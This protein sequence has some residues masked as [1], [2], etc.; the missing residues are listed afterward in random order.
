MNQETYIKKLFA[1]NR[2][3]ERAASRRPYDPD[4]YNNIVDAANL[5]MKRYYGKRFSARL[6]H[7][8]RI[9]K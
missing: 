6:L 8:F 9:F 4:E 5:L 1:L 2:E 3:L 7:L